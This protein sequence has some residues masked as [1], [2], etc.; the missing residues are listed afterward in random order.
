MDEFK[1]VGLLV[2]LQHIP[3]SVI[4][5]PPVEMTF[6]HNV[7]EFDSMFEAGLVVVTVGRATLNVLNE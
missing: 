5:P 7:A 4:V 1:Y 6:P 3:L 2:V